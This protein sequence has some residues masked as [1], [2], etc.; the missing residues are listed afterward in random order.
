MRCEGEEEREEKREENE[1]KVAE[2]VDG[3]GGTR[4]RYYFTVITPEG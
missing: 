4:T 2:R 1:T 3:G